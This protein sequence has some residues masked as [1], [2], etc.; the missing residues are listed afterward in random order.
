MWENVTWSVT[1]RHG[2]CG[3]NGAIAQA[4]FFSTQFWNHFLCVYPLYVHHVRVCFVT[5]LKIMLQCIE[6]N[7]QVTCYRCLFFFKMSFGQAN[8]VRV[9]RSILK[10]KLSP[11][12]KVWHLIINLEVFFI[13]LI[14]YSFHYFSKH[15]RSRVFKSA[16]SLNFAAVA[17]SRLARPEPV[18]LTLIRVCSCYLCGVGPTAARPEPCWSDVFI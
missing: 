7:T 4:F 6:G 1:Y 5:Y 11:I 8:S 9:S 10:L 16:F 12:L 15:K 13:H 2:Q 3:M 14:Y 17:L 18:N